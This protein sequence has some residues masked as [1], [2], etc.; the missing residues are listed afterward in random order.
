MTSRLLMALSDV[1][2]DVDDVTAG[3]DDVTTA[4]D[5]E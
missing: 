2:A 3:A 5:T 4:Y 1:T